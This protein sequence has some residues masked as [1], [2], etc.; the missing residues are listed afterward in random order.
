VRLSRRPGCDRRPRSSLSAARSDEH[1]MAAARPPPPK[2]AAHCRL[3][4]HR[5]RRG[6]HRQG[7][8][9]SPPPVTALGKVRG[10]GPDCSP[11]RYARRQADGD[12]L[13]GLGRYDAAGRRRGEGSSQGQPAPAARLR[14]HRRHRRGLVLTGGDFDLSVNSGC[15]LG[16]VLK[17][18]QKRG[19]RE[20]PDQHRR[21]GFRADRRRALRPCREQRRPRP[22]GAVTVHHRPQEC[23]P[24]D[25]VHPAPRSSDRRHEG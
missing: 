20:A 2:Q 11:R 21:M 14:R 16:D 25:R 10:S 7:A 4:A 24:G 15:R 23:R 22:A 5:G 9:L 6:H 3:P 13:N 17:L 19:E 12:V 8:G 18:L 1:R